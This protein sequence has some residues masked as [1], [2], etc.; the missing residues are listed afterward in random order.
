MAIAS[1]FQG[2]SL[3]V[4]VTVTDQVT[5]IPFDLTGATVLA[6]AVNGATKIAGT[7]DITNATGGVVVLSWAAGVL[8]AGEWLIQA[9][10]EVGASSQTVYVDS[11]RVGATAIA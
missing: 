7:A 10:V 11:L 9:R 3:A 2:D 4:E 6:G 1:I 5:G 8:P